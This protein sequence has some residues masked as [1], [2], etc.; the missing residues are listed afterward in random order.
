[1]IEDF[2]KVL[3]WIEEG[4]GSSIE[5]K[6]LI[7][8]SEK[9]ART[10]CSMANHKGGVIL[11][12][13][14][15]DGEI[16]GV[17]HES[18]FRQL[19][20]EAARAC[21]TPPISIG[22]KVYEQGFL[23]VLGVHIEESTLKPHRTISKDGSDQ[24]YVRVKDKSMPASKEVERQL[25]NDE[26]GT[27]KID[28]PLDSKEK[29]LIVYLERNE[30]ITLSRYMHLMNLSKRRARR[31][32]VNLVKEGILRVHNASGEDLYTLS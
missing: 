20:L 6:L 9:I 5:F 26:L 22:I 32:L 1:M 10:I 24:V 2:T 3:E 17:R 12:G 29:G 23:R 15:D 27:Q 30:Q 19:L 16:E 28:R 11:I 7:K 13:V 31:I 25:L 21:C 4:E 8:E 18:D 14:S